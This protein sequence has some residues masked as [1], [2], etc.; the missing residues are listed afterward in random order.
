LVTD[1]FELATLEAGKSPLHL[2]PFSVG[3]LAQDVVQKYRLA[4]EDADVDLVAVLPR[5]LPF[6]RGD[7]ALV[8][9]ALE[10]LL[11]NALHHTP[12]GGTVSVLLERRDVGVQ[13]RVEDT[14]CGIVPERLA[15]ILDRS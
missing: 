3:E 6:V 8:E 11:Q 9:R 7:I 1:L 12:A 10:N 14:G 13:I 15:R 5:D 4:A 2:E